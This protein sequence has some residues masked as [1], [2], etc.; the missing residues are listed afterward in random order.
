M[1]TSSSSDRSRRRAIR[2]RKAETGESYTA[3][4]RALAGA[5]STTAT[6]DPALLVPYPDETNMDVDELGWRV[7]PADATPAQRAHAEA[8][9]RPVNPARPCRCCGSCLHATQCGRDDDGKDRCPGL[10]IHVDR[11]PG[12]LFSVN[13]WEDVYE[14]AGCGAVLTVS[15]ELPAVPWGEANPAG[16]ITVY[17]KVRHPNFPDHDEDDGYDPGCFECGARAGY[18]C[19]CDDD[20]QDGCEECG[21]GGP[22]GCNC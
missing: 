4:G 22:Y 7:L 2:M 11:Y 17:D 15:V 16:G 19:T 20:P 6:I 21:G 12:G 8:Y 10:L 18:R 1:T 13:D 5:G 14:C 9:W 3:A